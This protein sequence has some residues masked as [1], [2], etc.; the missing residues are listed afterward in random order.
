MISTLGSPFTRLTPDAAGQLLEAHWGIRATDLTRLDTENDDTYRVLT[1]DSDRFVLKIARPDDDA[2]Q[3]ELQCAALAHAGRRDPSLPLQRGIRSTSGEL[4]PRLALPNG[5]VRIARVLSYLPG[6]LLQSTPCT[7][8]QL[9][10]VGLSLARLARALEDF[11]HPAA[12]RE[13]PWDLHRLAALVPKLDCVE[14]PGIRA[15]LSIVLQQL[16]TLTL[17]LLKSLPRQV[18]HNDFHGGNV[19]VDRAAPAFVTGILD[20]GDTVSSSRAAN[21]AVAMSYAAGYLS[22]EREADPWTAANA[23]RDGY[24]EVDPL[25]ELELELL[26]PLAVGRLLQRFVLGSW[27]AASDPT[28]APYTARALDATLHQFR[29]VSHTIYPEGR[30]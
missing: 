14:D 20:F 2:A 15:E 22:G 29:R 28:N 11:D 21:L 12:H 30:L 6:A 26:H 4:L 3:I 5:E 8:E 23:L 18:V 13:F 9:H 27:L 19:I 24:L 17:P 25:T 10:A 16:L 7:L 1:R